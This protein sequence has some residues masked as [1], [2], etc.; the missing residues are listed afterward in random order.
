MET[1]HEMA[2][3]RTAARK[4]TWT[5]AEHTIAAVAQAVAPELL[6]RMFV[7][8]GSAKGRQPGWVMPEAEWITLGSPRTADE[9]A[10]ALGE[11]P[12]EHCGSTDEVVENDVSSV[13]ECL[14]CRCSPGL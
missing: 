2:L 1:H 12:C 8:P 9:W 6:A 5:A 11:V 7:G 4:A 3:R 14:D 10:V 13:Q